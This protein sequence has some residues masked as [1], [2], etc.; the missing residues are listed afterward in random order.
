MSATQFRWRFYDEDI[1]ETWSGWHTMDEPCPSCCC[2]G[3][4]DGEHR[5]QSIWYDEF[6]L[7]VFSG[8]TR[9]HPMLIED[10]HQVEFRFV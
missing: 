3:P 2:G 4:E 8:H 6:D 7:P 1:G 9:L 10:H 5:E